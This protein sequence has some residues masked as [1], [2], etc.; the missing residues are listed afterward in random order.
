MKKQPFFLVV[1][2]A[3]LLLWL[4]ACSSA[5]DSTDSSQLRESIEPVAFGQ[6]VLL[7]GGLGGAAHT[8][9]EGEIGNTEALSLSE[10]FGVF[11]CHTGRYHYG[12]S[13]ACPDFMYNQ[14][15]SYLDGYNV[16]VYS[17]V[18]YWPQG[19]DL[20]DTRYVSFFAY[21]PY[22]NGDSSDADG[23]PEGYCIPQ[24]SDPSAVG[25]PYLMYRLHSDPA[26]QVDL[27]IA[28]PL[29][30]MSKPSKTSDKLKFQFRHALATVGD[31]VK[32]QASDELKALLNSLVD[33]TA[34]TSVS[35]RLTLVNIDYHLTERGQLSLWNNGT[36]QWR[37]FITEQ[38]LT[39]RSVSL[40]SAG[41]EE[42][43]RYNGAASASPFSTTDL[44]VF[45]IPAHQTGYEQTA[46]VT[47]GY[48]IVTTGPGGST[49]P[50]TVSGSLVLSDF[51][52]YA[53]G[54]KLGLNLFLYVNRL[55]IGALGVTVAPWVAD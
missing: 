13:D 16:W 21:A 31:E 3:V 18:K 37:T 30:D 7:D 53:P 26:K 38:I 40:L 10:G 24:F 8:R 19:N 25:N 44:G 50:V 46:A 39:T 14:Q 9:A 42:V 48:N 51:D 32:I 55:V 34:V 28:P 5:D 12:A 1:L 4:S 45:Y 54:K 36:P 20:D 49:I 15:V 43:Y 41:N 33:G 27:L 35:L 6:Q 23:N 22:S 2:A 47:V 52:A 11:A 17:P 29:V